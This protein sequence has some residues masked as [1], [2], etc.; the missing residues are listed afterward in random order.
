MQEEGNIR[1]KLIETIQLKNP[2]GL[3]VRPASFVA[4]L[5]KQSNSEVSLTYREKTIDARS[6]ISLLI[7]SLAQGAV[8]TVTVEGEDAEVTMKTL[9]TAFD[10]NFDEEGP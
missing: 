5:V 3:H 1:L 8:I 10:N 9:V 6:I 7:L 2:L 4:K